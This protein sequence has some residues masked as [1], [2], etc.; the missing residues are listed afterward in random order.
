MLKTISFPIYIETPL[1]IT[2]S[3]IFLTS[4]A[5]L[6]FLQL[7][8][9]FTKALIFYHFDQKRYIWVKTDILSYIIGSILSQPILDFGQWHPVAFFLKKMISVEIW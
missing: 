8:K 7:R 1:K 5:K 9:T 6:P 3:S 2:R 4:E